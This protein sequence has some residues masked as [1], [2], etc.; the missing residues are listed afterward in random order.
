MEINEI[1]LE[2]LH[3]EELYDLVMRIGE[4]TQSNRG[5]GV[6]MTCLKRLNMGINKAIERGI[7]G[8]IR[9]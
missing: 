8:E 1:N 2:E 9:A 7:Y 5:S 4:Y 3:N 6:S